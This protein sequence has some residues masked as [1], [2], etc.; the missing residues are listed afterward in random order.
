[1][2]AKDDLMECVMEAPVI[3]AVYKLETIFKCL[4]CGSR[5]EGGLGEAAARCRNVQCGVLNNTVFCDKFTSAELLIVSTSNSEKRVLTAYGQDTIGQLVGNECS[6]T[7]EALL[8]APP[9]GKLTY[10]NSEIVMVFRS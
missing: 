1:M 7:E 8:G 3:A 9:I 5:T 6:V 10:K 2:P 4:R